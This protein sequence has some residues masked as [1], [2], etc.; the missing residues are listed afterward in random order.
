MCLSRVDAPHGGGG[1]GA[2]GGGGGG[3]YGGGGASEADELAAAMMSGVEQASDAAL[4]A[5]ASGGDGS[6]G[7]GASADEQARSLRK[8]LVASLGEAARTCGS[9]PDAT[10][11]GYFPNASLQEAQWCV[12]TIVEQCLSPR[13]GTSHRPHNPPISCVIG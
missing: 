4:L 12:C 9:D 11:C 2:Y 6:G 5:L 7:G 3:A 13:I 8:L 10:G 1:G